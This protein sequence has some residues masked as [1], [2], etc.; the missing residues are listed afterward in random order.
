MENTKE[1]FDTLCN[2]IIE[3]YW[4]Y[5]EKMTLETTLEKD[6]GITGDDGAEFLEK[7]ITRFVFREI[8]NSFSYSI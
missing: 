1:I 7:F 5:R 8:Y 3:E 2:F 6:L 4:G